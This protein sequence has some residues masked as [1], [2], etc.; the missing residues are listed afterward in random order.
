MERSNLERDLVVYS[1]RDLLSR[2]KI[3]RS[4]IQLCMTQQRLDLIQ[5]ST[6]FATQFRTGTA[7]MPR[8]A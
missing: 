3:D 2:L 8:A 5:L 4:G 7:L 1:I 6:G